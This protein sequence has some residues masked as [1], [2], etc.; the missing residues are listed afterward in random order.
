[1]EASWRKTRVREAAWKIPQKGRH[2]RM[3]LN[4]HSLRCT[5]HA[6]SRNGRRQVFAVEFTASRGCIGRLGIGMES[7]GRS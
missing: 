4:P 5:P 7:Q 6:K 2:K 3:G 1:M